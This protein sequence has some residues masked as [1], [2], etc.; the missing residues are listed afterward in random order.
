MYIKFQ[1]RLNR[2]G[3]RVWSSLSRQHL[4]KVVDTAIE[5]SDGGNREGGEFRSDRQ[6]DFQSLLQD[7][8]TGE[9]QVAR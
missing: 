8:K 3:E 7:R 5:S 2:E 4:S 9:S 1:A 6:R